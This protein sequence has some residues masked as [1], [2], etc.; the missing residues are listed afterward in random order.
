MTQIVATWMGREKG[1]WP[2]KDFL[3]LCDRECGIGDRMVIE[4]SHQQSVTKRAMFHATLHDVYIN[5]PED[6]ASR[7]LNIEHFRK[8]LTIS[9]GFATEAQIAAMSKAEAI[10][11]AGVLRATDAY[12]VVTVKDAIVT[13]WRARSTSAR[14]MD[15]KTFSAL[16]DAVLAK[17]AELIGVTP[18]ELRR[19]H[20]NDRH[21]LELPSETGSAGKAPTGAEP[22]E[23]AVEVSSPSAA[24]KRRQMTWAEAVKM[25][26]P[27]P[28]VRRTV[29][30]CGVPS[31]ADFTRQ[32][33]MNE[34][35]TAQM[36]AVSDKVPGFPLGMIDRNGRVLYFE[37]GGF[38]K[39]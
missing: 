24:G 38:A 6:V 4:F 27:G 26:R 15:G 3:D 33:A 20:E 13:Q 34:L 16:V 39:S 37:T 35:A 17:A 29:L 1:F 18:D 25:L 9:A 12:S 23:P 31:V 5:L 22:V 11:I 10:R 32:E 14:E 7:Y 36:I 30:K 19:Q 21:K 2:R 28:T 8:T